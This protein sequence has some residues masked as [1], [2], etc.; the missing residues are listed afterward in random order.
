MYLRFKVS[1]LQIKTFVI[2][3]RT[4][5]L[6]RNKK[7]IS[8]TRNGINILKVLMGYFTAK[9]RATQIDVI[10]VFPFSF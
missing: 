10:V 3:Q 8:L 7:R 4:N 6:D 9:V 2:A 1:S 5:F